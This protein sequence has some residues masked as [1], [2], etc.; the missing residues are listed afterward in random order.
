MHHNNECKRNSLI[1][2]SLL[3][4]IML[5]RHWNKLDP[6]I[7]DFIETE[8]WVGIPENKKQEMLF[9]LKDPENMETTLHFSPGCD[10]IKLKIYRPNGPTQMNKMAKWVF[11]LGISDQLKKHGRAH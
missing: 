8:E 5:V 10:M 3:Q 4:I 11:I 6:V 2:F 1:C 9:D 7:T